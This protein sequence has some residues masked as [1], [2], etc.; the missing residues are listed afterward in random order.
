MFIIIKVSVNNNIPEYIEKF[1]SNESAIEYLYNNNLSSN[2][3]SYLKK[4]SSSDIIE[5]Y[6][7]E[8]NILMPNRSIL[9][10]KY[11][12]IKIEN[13]KNNKNNKNNII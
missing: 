5:Y 12:I 11:K 7:R 9:V 13:N 2:K 10:A 4:I 3:N 6:E 8:D 1:N